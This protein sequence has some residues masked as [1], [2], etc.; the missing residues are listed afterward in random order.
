MF[1][2]IDP[3]KLQGMMS[4]M[5]IKQETIPAERVII[6]KSDGR[7]IINNPK[8]V[9]INMQGQ[10]SFQI[11]GDISESEKSGEENTISEEDIQTVVEKTGKSEEEARESL[12]KTHDIAESILELSD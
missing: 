9:K 11:T 8:V 5:G 12:E 6:E 1:G 2:G 7:M 4:K 10:E 3:K